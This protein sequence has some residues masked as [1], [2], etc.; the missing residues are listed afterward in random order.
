MAQFTVRIELRDADRE[1]YEVLYEQMAMRG[2]TD[3]V[4][5]TDGTVYQMPDAEYNYRG[6]ATRQEVLALAKGAAAMT[7]VEYSVLVTESAGRVWFN[8]KPARR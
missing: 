2:F 6:D 7:G 8:L 4:T 3:T 5:N 1:E